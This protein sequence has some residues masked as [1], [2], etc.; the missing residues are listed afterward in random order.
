MPGSKRFA[1]RGLLYRSP[2]SCLAPLLLV[3]VMVSCGA[4]DSAD[5]S[6]FRR[7]TEG[8][9]IPILGDSHVAWQLPLSRP[10]LYAAEIANGSQITVVDSET[11]VPGGNGQTFTSFGEMAISGTRLAFI[12]AGGGKTQ[13]SENGIYLFD[14]SSRVMSKVV[15][16]ADI[17][18][19]ID[20][21]D[22]DT[23]APPDES[24]ATFKDL[25]F[26]GGVLVFSTDGFNGRA[27]VYFWDG[28]EVKPITDSYTTI[29]YMED[30]GNATQS[31]RNFGNVSTNGSAAAFTVGANS[32]EV[33][34]SGMF[35]EG[36]YTKSFSSDPNEFPTLARDARNLGIGGP[37]FKFFSVCDF[38]GDLIAFRGAFD[39]GQDV[40]NGFYTM[41][42][43]GGSVTEIA[44]QGGSIPGASGSTWAFNAFIENRFS[45]DG[46]LTVFR[47]YEE[48]FPSETDGI[49]LD[50]ETPLV[51]RG[52]TVDGGS[53]YTTS[54][55][56]KSA[57]DGRIAFFLSFETAEPRS[58]IFITG[59]GESSE[60]A[61]DLSLSIFVTNNNPLV[62]ED[63]MAGDL[64]NFSVGVTNGG[65]APTTGPITVTV[66][67]P[68]VFD[69]D[70]ASGEGWSFS[71]EGTMLTAVRDAPLSHETP[72]TDEFTF[73]AFARG[74]AVPSVQIS[75]SVSTPGETNTANNETTVSVSVAPSQFPVQILS[76]REGQF[77]LSGESPRIVFSPS[78]KEP[79]VAFRVDWD[80][81]G[82]YTGFERE[83]RNLP[84]GHV[85]SFRAPAVPTHLVDEAPV[86]FRAQVVHELMDTGRIQASDIATVTT[87]VLKTP[88]PP[89]VTFIKPS[90]NAVIRGGV[91]QGIV[92]EAVA[93]IG[94]DAGILSGPSWGVIGLGNPYLVNGE[95]ERFVVQRYESGKV[96]FMILFISV[97]VNG[98]AVE[99][100]FPL[101]TN[102]ITLRIS[103][104]DARDEQTNVSLP[105]QIERDDLQKLESTDSPGSA[106]GTNQ[107]DSRSRIVDSQV[108]N[109]TISRS[110]IVDSTVSSSVIGD[111]VLLP[112]VLAI[113]AEIDFGVVL[114]GSVSRGGTTLVPP[115]QLAD[116]YEQGQFGHVLSTVLTGDVDEDGVFTSNDLLGLP[117]VW[118]QP[119]EAFDLNLDE[120]VSAEDLLEIIAHW[121]I[122]SSKTK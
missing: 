100:V 15:D 102:P 55:T 67:L 82:S 114:S 33:D 14:L 87:K 64:A 26:Y 28:A 40:Q 109:S 41:S 72:F 11:L 47:G 71:V 38:K 25:D 84:A 78:S 110:L 48:G 122:Q 10:R 46:S 61:A 120:V 85:I 17:A 88:R 53:V 115:A 77:V 3:S 74:E 107:I 112:G 49:Y 12:G 90:S 62:T 69:F 106:K 97:S 1:D 59:S 51:E 9:T 19:N 111:S 73:T 27:G 103:V 23:P 7:I 42:P 4:A 31:F 43:G 118:R 96:T 70:G 45:T 104:T 8:G 21:V 20:P 105:L 29:P 6:T 16:V 44:R 65:N 54:V 32:S 34:G 99:E 36:I 66:P 57:R 60:E 79:I 52:D 2:F 113:G 24:F 86:T 56:R 30:V 89:V 117:P 101:A 93:T 58:G 35:V 94:C 119:S 50:G 22:E 91:S 18:P 92:F 5:L 63:L 98:D 39:V 81:Y 76:P 68:E 116:L 37:T 75:P 108:T 80:G 83:S 95:T 121:K 13:P